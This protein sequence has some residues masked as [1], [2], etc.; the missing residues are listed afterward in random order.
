METKKGFIKLNLPEF[1][2]W[3]KNMHVARTIISV[4]EHHTYSPSYALF[5]GSNH[6]DLQQGMKNYHITHNGWQDI[7]QQFT[8]FPDGSILT[9]RSLEL[10]PACITGQNSGAVCIENL[11]N[12][13]LGFDQMTSAHR[14]TIIGITA[15]LCKRFN[16][17]LDENHIV[18]H[19]WFDVTSG[20][21]NNGTKNNKS[22]PGTNFFGGNKVSDFRANFL[23][24]VSAAVVASSPASV[25]VL[26]Y[27]TVNTNSLNIRT[28]PGSSYAKATDR[29]PVTLGSIL[30][31][32]KIDNGWYKIS[33]SQDN[34]VASNYTVNVKRAVVIPNRLN[35]RSGPGTTFP[36]TGS[37]LKGQEIFI[38]KTN[39]AWGQVAMSDKWV[40]VT[41]LDMS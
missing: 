22:C 19:H 27:A 2:N 28:G 5:N 23:P 24:L 33:N 7:A 25:D 15:I 10:S 6:F 13:D 36:V 16:L 17:T 9:G 26:K 11:G 30:R 21:R 41:Y 40:N 38:V 4:Q 35:S 3:L 29:E 32:Y 31:V 1:E 20:K 14:E 8:T 37:F 34:W 39:G 12:F 18:Y